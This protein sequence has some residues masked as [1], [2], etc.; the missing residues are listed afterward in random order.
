MLKL[1]PMFNPAVK[2]FQK[3]NIKTICS[4]ILKF[5]FELYESSIFKIFVSLID[6]YERAELLSTISKVG[7]KRNTNSI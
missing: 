4:W 3:E 2:S 6:V 7:N 5:F 1:D